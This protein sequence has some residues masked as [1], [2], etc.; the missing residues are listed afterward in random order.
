MA[1]IAENTQAAAKAMTYV[2]RV[3]A[4][5]AQDKADGNMTSSRPSGRGV[6]DGVAR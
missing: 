2:E 1:E 4:K 6:D 5:S 3:A